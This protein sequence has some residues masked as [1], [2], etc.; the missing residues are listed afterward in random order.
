[1]KLKNV[2]FHNINFMVTLSKIND[3]DMPPK[4][5]YQFFVL[6]KDLM[7]RFRQ[8]EQV[9]MKILEKHGELNKEEQRFAISNEK[10][11]AFEKDFNEL[12][13]LKFDITLEEKIPYPK[14]LNLSPS[15]ILFFDDIMDFSNL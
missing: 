1:M 15:Q 3:C 5:A 2:I 9:R 11:E 10:L 13:Q 4:V 6:S 12:L 7:E 8:Y 14:E